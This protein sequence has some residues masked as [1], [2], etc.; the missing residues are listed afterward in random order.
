MQTSDFTARFFSEFF[1]HV[2]STEAHNWDERRFG[3]ED[4]NFNVDTAVFN[5]RFALA[6]FDHIAW[7]YDQLSDASSRDYLIRFVLYKILGHTHVRLPQNTPEFW[8]FYRSVESYLVT[9]A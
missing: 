7:F 9:R 6:N 2:H 1:Q 4:R 8:E 3:A 5:M